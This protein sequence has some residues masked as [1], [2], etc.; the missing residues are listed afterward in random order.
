MVDEAPK[1]GKQDAHCPVDDRPQHLTKWTVSSTTPEGSPAP[2][3]MFTTQAQ[4]QNSIT[5]AP[6]QDTS[7]ILEAL[8][9]MAQQSAHSAPTASMP[10]QTGFNLPFGGQLNQSQPNNPVN[11]MAS[12]TPSQSVNP[13]GNLFNGMGNGMQNHNPGNAS[14][15]M[16]PF[17]F[18]SQAQTSQMPMGQANGMPATQDP[19]A[20][21]QILQMLAAQ[22]V[23]P[24][25]W[26]AVL[27]ILNMQN[28][29][30][31]NNLL[32]Q[33]LTPWNQNA[34]SRDAATRSPPSRDR[35][36]RGRSRSPDVRGYR[37]N[38]PRRRRESPQDNRRGNDYR[39]RSPDR[40]RR[41]PTPPPTDQTL[42][43]PGPKTIIIDQTLPRG[44]I[45][46]LSRTLFVGG[47]TSSESHLRSL[48]ATFGVVQ[49]CI[50]NIDKRHAFVKMLTRK[51]AVAARAGMED[52]KTG[53]IQ[54]RVRSIHALPLKYLLTDF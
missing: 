10:A 21:L 6:Q 5:P 29:G 47:V 31:A 39:R 28:G 41:S 14:Q 50:V 33:G 44:H 16:T 15:N 48:F 54:L 43:P 38:S 4:A 3:A 8:K 32:G 20:Q 18:L 34:G 19:Q 40:R 22:G 17:N 45:K 35:D 26:P 12:A 42:P 46:V 11:A 37:G 53:E 1:T 2:D 51:D 24:D 52:Y 23:P 13:L 9:T 25:Q 7:A 36:H 49:T 27:Q 30:A